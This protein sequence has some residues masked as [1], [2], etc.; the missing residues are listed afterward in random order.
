[1]TFKD[2]RN[3]IFYN[4][5]NS[6]ISGFLVFLGSIVSGEITTKG[7]AAAIAT[8][9]IVS[10]VKFKTYWE[11]QEGEYSSTSSKLNKMLTFI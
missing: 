6:L 8:A 11:T 9:G 7:I 1:M 2:N 4:I 10:I 5:V 3:E